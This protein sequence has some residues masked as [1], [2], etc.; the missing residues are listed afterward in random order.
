VPHVHDHRLRPTAAREE[1]AQ[2]L[3]WAGKFLRRVLKS[4]EEFTAKDS[5]ALF[6]G[7]LSPLIEK[8]DELHDLSSSLHV[9]EPTRALVLDGLKYRRERL[10]EHA[11]RTAIHR[12]ALSVRSAEQPAWNGLEHLLDYYRAY[13][14]VNERLA[15]LR[16]KILDA[17]VVPMP[18]AEESPTTAPKVIAVAPP[19]QGWASICKAVGVAHK[20]WR[21]LKEW[22]A[23]FQGPIKV[24]GR[25]NPPLVSEQ[26]L[27][28]WWNA[29][30]S[31]LTK[32][33]EAPQP[34]KVDLKEAPYGKKGLVVP[35]DSGYAGMGVKQ[36]RSDR[37]QQRSP[38]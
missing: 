35:D 25:R 24:R 1:A 22:N 16:E 34:P 26:D 6:N 3:V 14:L 9:P 12:L 5:R 30:V 38:K 7:V 15:K 2:A 29:L 21:K 10:K 27:F 13:N 37:G 4:P 19:I 33:D 17:R 32:E 31:R 8:W 20:R 23:E 36:R 18:V 11:R 28:V